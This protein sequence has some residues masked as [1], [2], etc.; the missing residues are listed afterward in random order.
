[1]TQ[2]IGYII[3]YQHFIFS[4]YKKNTSFK[5]LL[6]LATKQTSSQMQFQSLT[7]FLFIIIFL[8][9]H[10]TVNTSKNDLKNR[11]YH[12]F[13]AKEFIYKIVKLI[14]LSKLLIQLLFLQ[15]FKQSVFF[16]FIIIFKIFHANS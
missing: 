6:I 7:D 12:F 14:P 4:I 16:P 2:T 13:Q 8:F 10:S 11:F 3:I 9:I 1:M 15:H 5:R